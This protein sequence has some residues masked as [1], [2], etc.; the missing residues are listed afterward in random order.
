MVTLL[1]NV[2]AN[3]RRPLIGL[4]EHIKIKERIE[5]LYCAK[6]L[7]RARLFITRSFTASKIVL[8]QLRRIQ[9]KF[10]RTYFY[11]CELE[12]LGERLICLNL[13]ELFL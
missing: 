13:Y 3:V 4:N 2:I 1:G 11:I 12:L 10:S 7:E 9:V 5:L 8:I 6:I